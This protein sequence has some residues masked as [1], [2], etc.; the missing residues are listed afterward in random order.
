M[1]TSKVLRS[2]L[3][4]Y[5]HQIK[6]EKLSNKDTYIIMKKKNKEE[7]LRILKSIFDYIIFR[8]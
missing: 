7:K 2:R 5:F 1:L 8:K 4:F 6:K 3:P